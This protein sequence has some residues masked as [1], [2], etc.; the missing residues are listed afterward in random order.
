MT[1][2][3]AGSDRWRV[4]RSVFQ[5]GGFCDAKI[6]F[7]SVV[8]MRDKRWLDELVAAWT[9]VDEG[10]IGGSSSPAAW[11]A[12]SLQPCKADRRRRRSR[13]PAWRGG[14]SGGDEAGSHRVAAVAIG[15][16]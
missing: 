12:R 1:S 6:E 4:E 2:P 10:P 16:R 14:C 7:S 9:L 15:V 5:Q 11:R 8:T 13:F 3:N